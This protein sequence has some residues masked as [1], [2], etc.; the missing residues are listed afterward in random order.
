MVCGLSGDLFVVVECNLETRLS[1]S[2]LPSKHFI[3]L[4]LS[5]VSMCLDLLNA[6]S[7]IIVVSSRLAT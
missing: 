6:A 3:V 7:I 5:V 2:S 1:L 4:V